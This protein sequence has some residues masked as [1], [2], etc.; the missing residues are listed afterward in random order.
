[1]IT[2]VLC[3][4]EKFNYTRIVDLLKEDFPSVAG[5]EQQ[6]ALGKFPNNLY[7]SLP[8]ENMEDEIEQIE[9]K[10]SLPFIPFDNPFFTHCEF[11]SISTAKK[12]INNLLIDFPELFI[13]DENDERY[14]AREFLQSEF[15]VS[16]GTIIRL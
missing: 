13:V 4:K 1:M 6:V 3:S 7:I 15:D 10:D 9:M 14:T 16:Q 8:S 12:V 5:N 2:I 11:H